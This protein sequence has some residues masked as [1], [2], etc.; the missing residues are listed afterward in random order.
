VLLDQAGSGKTLAYLLPIFQVGLSHCQVL[1]Q[2]APNAGCVE[3]CRD[4][5]VADFCLL[6]MSNYVPASESRLV[7]HLN[8]RRCEQRMQQQA[9]P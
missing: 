8:H 6:A 7:A 9:R 1:L 5:S 2:A 4:A 3:Q